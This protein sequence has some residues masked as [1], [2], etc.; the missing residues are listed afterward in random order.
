MRAKKLEILSLH[1]RMRKNSRFLAQN[2]NLESMETD[3]RPSNRDIPGPSIMRDS[4]MSQIQSDA[5]MAFGDIDKNE[6]V[7][8][9]Y[10]YVSE[11]TTTGENFQ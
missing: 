7:P 1:L 8:T 2:K 4:S 6:E 11:N 3:K 9:S 5:P 10:S